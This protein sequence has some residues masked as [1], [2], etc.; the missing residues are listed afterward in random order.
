MFIDWTLSESQ[1][2]IIERPQQSTDIPPQ[3]EESTPKPVPIRRYV[4]VVGKKEGPNACDYCKAADAELPETKAIK[5]GHV[6]YQFM[7]VDTDEAEETLQ[8]VGLSR[9]KG[10][11]MP[12]IMDCTEP[13][14]KSAKPA[15][16]VY[17]GYE[18]SDFYDLN[19]WTP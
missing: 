9:K 4:N 5:E 16:K 15:C 11:H 12:V 8:S 1:T 13:A 3:P 17:E 7:D 2:E 6:P 14:D 18:P 19:N 10:V